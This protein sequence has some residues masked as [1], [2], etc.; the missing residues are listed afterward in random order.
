MYQSP[1]FS[2]CIEN[3]VFISVFISFHPIPSP[4][5]PLPSPAFCFLLIFYILFSPF[6]RSVPS[7][8]FPPLQI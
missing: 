2:I 4:F 7:P 6:L 8:S 5:S 3:S 1:L